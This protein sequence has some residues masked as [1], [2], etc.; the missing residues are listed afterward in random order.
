VAS[1]RVGRGALI[2]GVSGV[3]LLASLFLP[4]YVVEAPYSTR[5]GSAW[6]ELQ[7]IDLLLLLIGLAAV[8][9]TAALATDALEPSRAVAK[10]VAVAGLLGTALILFRILDLPTPDVPP[11]FADLVEFGLRPGA[12]AGLAAA[13]GISVGGF[14]ASRR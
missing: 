9:W 8:G 5:T 10:A 6:T 11:R 7:L 4:W 3:V 2:A 12:F 1:G 13:V 14:V